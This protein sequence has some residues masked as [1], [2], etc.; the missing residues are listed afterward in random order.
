MTSKVI[1][2]FIIILAAVAGY[3]WGIQDAA[4]ATAVDLCAPLQRIQVKATRLHEATVAHLETSKRSLA[5][6]RQV[7]T[8]Y[9]LATAGA[10]RSQPQE[11][12]AAPHDFQPASPP[13]N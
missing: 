2:V 7:S 8:D 13:P 9:V 3:I 1:L 10:R 6:T 5:M 4:V 12:E 11:Y